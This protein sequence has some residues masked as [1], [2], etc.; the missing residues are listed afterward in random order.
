M[1]VVELVD[2]QARLLH[3]RIIFEDSCDV[4]NLDVIWKIRDVDLACCLGAVE[5]LGGVLVGLL[6]VGSVNG[7]LVKVISWAGWIFL[8]SFK[9]MVVLAIKSRLDSVLGHRERSRDTVLGDGVGI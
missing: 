1:L 4:F 6:K 5:L 2:R 8:S 3:Q 7:S 9:E